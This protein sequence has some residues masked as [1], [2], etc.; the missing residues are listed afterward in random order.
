MSIGRK[1]GLVMKKHTP[2]FVQMICFWL[3]GSQPFHV[4]QV[5]RAKHSEKNLRGA[6]PLGMVDA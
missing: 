1:N 3:V 4:C 5:P 6:A 2:A